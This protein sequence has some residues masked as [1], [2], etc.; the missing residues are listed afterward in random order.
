MRRILIA[1][2]SEAF[3]AALEKV[4]C[5]EFD[6]RTC[7]DGETAQELLL[8]FQ[9]DV[10][11]LNFT[12]PYKDGLTL[13]QEAAYIP[14]VVLGIATY[15]SDYIQQTA[16]YLGVGYI[17]QMPTVNTVRVRVLDM[18]NTYENKQTPEAAVKLHLHILGIPTHLD[19]YRYLLTGIPLFAKDPNQRL[20]KELYP[21]IAAACGCNDPRSVE[22]SIRTAIETTWKHHNPAVWAKY[23]LPAKNG[24]IACPTNKAFIACLSQMIQ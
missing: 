21:N 5:A 22:H 18:L 23:F 15:I 1:D 24:K 14:P 11:I 20:S 16:F 19:G 8:S 7:M 4:F 6:V 12:L 2:M 10:L 9:P 13:L 3:A 17:L